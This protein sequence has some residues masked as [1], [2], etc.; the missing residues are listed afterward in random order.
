MTCAWSAS[1][2][3]LR[4]ASLKSIGYAARMSSAGSNTRRLEIFRECQPST[5]AGK[6]GARCESMRLLAESLMK[7]ALGEALMV[8]GKAT[9]PCDP[10][11]AAFDH[12]II[13]PLR[14]LD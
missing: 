5:A 6:A 3:A 11:N 4:K 7:A 13:I 8:A 12:P 10:S 9:P 14:H 2:V 1:I